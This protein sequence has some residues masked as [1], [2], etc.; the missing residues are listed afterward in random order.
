MAGVVRL[1]S[2]AC[3]NAA[4]SM[5]RHGSDVQASDSSDVAMASMAAVWSWSGCFVRQA[6]NVLANRW[7]NA[8]SFGI[9]ELLGESLKQSH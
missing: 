9:R 5:C 6:W 1:S 8:W 7:P 2:A 4:V 3:V